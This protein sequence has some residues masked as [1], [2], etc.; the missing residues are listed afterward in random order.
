MSPTRVIYIKAGL[1][2]GKQFSGLSLL[3][4]IF[5]MLPRRPSTQRPNDKSVQEI[6]SNKV[7]SENL[8]PC[9]LT[10]SV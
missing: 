7:K 2:T 10:G 3:L 9:G 5:W 8:F 1:T 4:F 6:K